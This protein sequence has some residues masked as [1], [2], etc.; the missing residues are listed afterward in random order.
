MIAYQ[1]ATCWTDSAGYLGD[2]IVFNYCI[3]NLI[4]MEKYGLLDAPHCPIGIMNI[5]TNCKPILI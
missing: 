1:V 3:E 4:R 2:V 5:I